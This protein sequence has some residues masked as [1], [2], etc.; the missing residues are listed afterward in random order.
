MKPKTIILWGNDDLLSTYVEHLLTNQK[1]WKV[2]NLTI[3]HKVD[4]VLRVMNKVNPH[5]VIIQ[6]G[7][8]PY[9]SSVPTILLQGHP[10]LQVVT[11]N[12]N[13]NLMEVYSKQDILINS[14]DDL[15][16]VIEA[17]F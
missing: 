3:G 1:G 7:D 9:N 4:E 10:D 17:N 15:I 5:I 13:N 8:R 12:L 6:M 2:V 16:S 11:L 14:A